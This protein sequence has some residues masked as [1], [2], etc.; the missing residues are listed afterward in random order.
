[1][2]SNKKA[3]PIGTAFLCFEFLL[4]RK[5]SSKGDNSL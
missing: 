4:N 2:I 5:D 1:M 3:V